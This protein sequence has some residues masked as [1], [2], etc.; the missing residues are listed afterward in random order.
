MA[1]F[2]H[3]SP[4]FRLIEKRTRDRLNLKILVSYLPPRWRSR[5]PRASPRRSSLVPIESAACRYLVS[6]W[7][8]GGTLRARVSAPANA[9][10]RCPC[11]NRKVRMCVLPVWT[12]R[13]ASRSDR[14]DPP[15]NLQRPWASPPSA[16]AA[17]SEHK[18]TRVTGTREVPVRTILPRKSPPHSSGATSAAAFEQW[19]WRA[20]ASHPTNRAERHSQRC[21]THDARNSPGTR[22][23]GQGLC[24]SMWHSLRGALF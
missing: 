14:H 19:P 18:M 8:R 15:Q 16:A 12:T 4:S 6:R 2:G 13:C 9:L 1:K 22:R 23:R 3:L 20:C 11:H 17:A 10:E 21:D 24:H 5:S 7:V